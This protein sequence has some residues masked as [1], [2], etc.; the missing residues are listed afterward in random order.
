MCERVCLYVL[1]NACL[2]PGAVHM[3][4]EAGCVDCES[5]FDI[6]EESVFLGRVLVFVCVSVSVWGMFVGMS[7]SQ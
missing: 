3:S 2:H 6:V 5:V 1:V 7:A 4:L